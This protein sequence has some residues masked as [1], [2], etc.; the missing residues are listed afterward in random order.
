[1]SERKFD[2]VVFER[3]YQGLFA[4]FGPAFLYSRY[5]QMSDVSIVTGNDLNDLSDEFFDDKRVKESGKVSE[6]KG[7]TD[8]FTLNVLF[9]PWSLIPDKFNVV[10]P[11]HPSQK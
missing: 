1:M 6:V 3:P 8:D 9:L 5:S 7:D 2:A 10:S 11:K 4:V